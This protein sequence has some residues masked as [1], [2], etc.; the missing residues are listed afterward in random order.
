MPA[1]NAQTNSGKD[2]IRRNPRG[3]AVSARA[4]FARA[5]R[6]PAMRMRRHAEQADAAAAL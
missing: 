2:G 5:G 4:A 3:R 6:L 1:A